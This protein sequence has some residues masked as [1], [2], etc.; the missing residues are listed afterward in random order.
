MRKAPVSEFYTFRQQV[1]SLALR[2]TGVFLI[3]L[4]LI[5][6]RINQF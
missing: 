4:Q 6:L 2:M 3:L 1:P 5:L